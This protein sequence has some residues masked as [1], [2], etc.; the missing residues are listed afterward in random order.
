MAGS[1]AALRNLGTTQRA[2]PS[3]GSQTSFQRVGLVTR[4][5]TD[6]AFVAR[7]RL[8]VEQ[9]SASPRDRITDLG[10]GE[11]SVVAQLMSNVS[12]QLPSARS[13]EVIAVSA[14]RDAS[15]SRAGESHIGQIA[16][17]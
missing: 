5:V 10:A 14:Y 7:T 6:E 15:A 2:R 11:P 8:E 13:K 1:G 17:N 9:A 3:I 4:G 16:C 12:L